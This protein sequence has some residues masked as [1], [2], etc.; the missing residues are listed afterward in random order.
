MARTHI[1]VPEL[2]DDVTEVTLTRLLITHGVSIAAEMP[3]AEVSTD[4][5][6]TEIPSPHTGTVVEI[7]VEEGDV[8]NVGTAIALI[9]IDDGAPDETTTAASPPHDTSAEQAD[10]AVDPEPTVT[11]DTD[12]ASRQKLSRIRQ[13]IA[14]R[15]MD[16]LHTSAQL[17]SVVEV[18]LSAVSR[19]RTATKDEFRHRTATKLSYLP[20]F[21]KAVVE[22]LDCHRLLTATIDDACTEI[23]YHD[24]VHLGIAVDSPRGLMVPVIH[25]AHR[26]NIRE[27]AI[28]IADVATRVR[29]GT[30]TPDALAGGTFTI[31]NTGSRGALFDTPILNKPQSAILGT[32]AVVDRVVPRRDGDNFALTVAPTV[33]LALTYDHRL[34]DGADAARFLS[35]VKNRLQSGFT[36]SQLQTC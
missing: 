26:L 31:T 33:L 24:G 14:T 16:S 19:L 22:A 36:A 28:G 30:I 13:V 27:L 25:D 6:D 3:V 2:G 11:A 29:E 17:T 21:A 1:T 8:I 23:T 9:E 18:D 35:D 4:K 12:N 5:V 20:F 7:L 32:G 10:A 34:I 15:M